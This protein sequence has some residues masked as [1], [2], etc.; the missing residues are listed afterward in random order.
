MQKRRI[1]QKIIVTISLM[2]M[3]CVLR[4]HASVPQTET[5]FAMTDQY[6]VGAGVGTYAGISA[7]VIGQIA[8]GTTFGTATPCVTNCIGAVIASPVIVAME[9]TTFVLGFLNSGLLN[10]SLRVASYDVLTNNL[11][12]FTS[13]STNPGLYAFAA[14]N[15]RCMAVFSETNSSSNLTIKRSQT[16]LSFTWTTTVFKNFPVSNATIHDIG[17]T[18]D[19]NADYAAVY[20]YSQATG[21]NAGYDQSWATMDDVYILQVNDAQTY[22]PS[23]QVA[24]TLDKNFAIVYQ[25][26]DSNNTSSILYRYFQ[27]TPS[28]TGWSSPATLIATNTS[29]LSEPL[30]AMNP[31]GEGTVVWVESV[32]TS[33]M[34]VMESHSITGM[35]DEWSSPQAI[36]PPNQSTSWLRV[37]V[38][39]CGN[40]FIIAICNINGVSWLQE[41]IYHRGTNSY[42]GPITIAPAANVPF[43][44]I[45]TNGYYV[46]IGY[47]LNGNQFGLL[48]QKL[49]SGGINYVQ[50]VNWSPDGRYLV[51]GGLTGMGQQGQVFAF[52][53]STLTTVTLQDFY[54]T[55]TANG[56]NIYSANW[57][58]NGSYIAFGGN[59]GGTGKEIQVFGGFAGCSQCT[60][61][62]NFVSG[63]HNQVGQGVG[64][65][66]NPGA[67]A[68]I[69]NVARFND[70]N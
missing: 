40:G 17:I 57:S 19:N 49:A 32:G 21:P 54:G 2:A 60:L 52:N 25:Q 15:G 62:N 37:V 39:N 5:P 34:V 42:E 4:V 36:F 22:V 27:Q 64:F 44:A 41:V 7:L 61:R 47:K 53:G 1:L 20:T 28:F 69:N 43:T 50:S 3:L 26:M 13:L 11:T 59:T 23:I 14:V 10:T 6:L 30:F 70:I 8:V 58:P 9:E 45:V 63:V 31:Q 48:W 35:P 12:N 38:D 46:C 29:M 51:A 16:N 68:L 18:I 66:V 55:S 24:G 56:T 67:N 33:S 65:F